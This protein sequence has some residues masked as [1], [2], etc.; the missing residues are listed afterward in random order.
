[1]KLCL[2]DQLFSE[3]EIRLKVQELALRIEH[4]ANNRPIVFIV[5]LNG[6]FIF[7]SD[8]IRYIQNDNI[9]LDTICTSLYKNDMIASGHVKLRKDIDLNL[10]EHYVVLIED[11]IDTGRTLK[12]LS[13]YI[14]NKYK[15]YCL[16][17]CTLLD[18][19]SR[20]FVDLKADYVGF[21]IDDLFVVGYGID[22][23][24]KY[25]QLPYISYVEQIIEDN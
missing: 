14:M 20:R 15:P 19:P 16:K 7:A 25:R 22:C 1:M 11:I 5:V 3:T 17:I 4:D 2:K 23:C 24:E 13:E 9:Q 8:L 10:Q 21:T 6:A 12:Y 18:K